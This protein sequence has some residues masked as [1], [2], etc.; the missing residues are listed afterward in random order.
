MLVKFYLAK[1]VRIYCIDLTAI[2]AFSYLDLSLSKDVGDLIALRGLKF[3]FVFADG[4]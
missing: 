1:P 2:I 3:Q 4:Y